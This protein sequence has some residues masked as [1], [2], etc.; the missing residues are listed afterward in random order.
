M[1]A[2]TIKNWIK[3]LP[4]IDLLRGLRIY[5]TKFFKFRKAYQTFCAMDVE[6]RFT[7]DIWAARMHDE[8]SVE[9]GF[10]RQ[11]VYHSAW[12]ARI[13]SRTRP[14]KHIDVSSLLYFSTLVSAFVPIEFYDY[15]RLH[16]E[17]DGLETGAA[18][19]LRLPFETGSV[20]SLSCMHVVEHI[21]LGRYGDPLDPEGDRKA[22]AELTRVLAPGGALLFVVPMGKMRLLFNAHR[23]YRYEAII[24]YFTGLELREFAFIPDNP[25]IGELLVNPDPQTIHDEMGCG[26]FYFVKPPK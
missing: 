4:G 17:L 3:R 16:V 13:L 12:A 5:G 9:H 8:S 21:G 15:R 24:T 10:D 14:V 7:S 6:K 23:E 18:D 2:L 20:N 1:S 25:L 26:C 22:I 19:L 11:Y